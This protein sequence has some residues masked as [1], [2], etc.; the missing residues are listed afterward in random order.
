MDEG[1]TL[2]SLHGLLGDR[3]ICFIASYDDDDDDD[4]V[5]TTTTMMMMMNTYDI[6]RG[7]QINNR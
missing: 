7:I 5:T 1:N 2:M 3:L 4:D 6:C